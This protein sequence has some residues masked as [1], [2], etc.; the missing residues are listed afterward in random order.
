MG[1]FPGFV[2]F[3]EC[4]EVKVHTVPTA[5]HTLLVVYKLYKAVVLRFSHIHVFFRF[6]LACSV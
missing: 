3:S 5:V 2:L 1:G 6:S 4:E